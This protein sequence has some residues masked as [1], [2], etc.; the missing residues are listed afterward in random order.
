MVKFNP[1]IPE[2]ESRLLS[3]P[4]RQNFN[5]LN[6]RTDQLS[7]SNT[8]PESTSITIGRGDKVY[9]QNNSYTPFTGVVLDLGN[10]STGVAA[11]SVANLYKKVIVYYKDTGEVDFV[12][13]P[14]EVTRDLSTTSVATLMSETSV[15]SALQGTIPI[16]CVLVTNNG[17]PSVR[18]AINPI[19]E[20]DLL[21]IRPFLQRTLDTELIDDHI[22]ATSL[23]EAHPNAKVGNSQI[24][25]TNSA[26]TSVVSSTKIVLAGSIADFTPDPSKNFYPVVRFSSGGEVLPSTQLQTAR[27]LSVSGNEVTLDRPVSV[28]TSFSASKGKLT[29][30]KMN[31]DILEEF[32]GSGLLRRRSSDGYIEF[33]P[34][35]SI[36]LNS[37]SATTFTGSLTGNASTASTLQTSR[38]IA[39]SGDVAG[40]VSFNGG[41]NVTIT[42]TIQPD[43]VV[44]GTDTTGNYVAAGATSGNG[45]S[46][47]V[48]S[49][50]GTFT[51]A[52]NATDSNS[53]STIV[54]RDG[55]GNFSAGTITATLSGN[56]SNVSGV[57]AIANGGTGQT[58]ANAGLNA[59]LP[60]QTTNANRVL[61][62]DGYNAG[63][64]QITD[65]Y[66][67][68]SAAI[69]DS[70]LATISTAGKVAN[71]ATSATTSSTANTIVLR[72]SDGYVSANRYLGGIVAGSGTINII[73]G[74]GKISLPSSASQ[75]ILTVSYSSGSI[76]LQPIRISSRVG[77]DALIEGDDGYG[78][79]YIAIKV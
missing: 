67:S 50:G 1:N 79:E 61:I 7:V 75:W 78:F 70:K 43:S 23:L 30:D 38:T 34:T 15:A 18:G 20:S 25:V 42:T 29:L 77:N 41:S 74:Y 52:S 66:I 2:S 4:I 28:T 53:P 60:S 17:T 51:V 39:L 16:C 26:I 59:L 63:W 13:G 3:A 10:S 64:S 62:T 49:E 5:A 46:G 19:F 31:F 22:N 33:Q 32:Q 55:Y 76:P 73:D 37:V 65:A 36:T 9:F 14:E 54:F 12:E 45:L 71:S 27:V 11:F 47:S 6:D 56:A 8:T 44:L 24:E 35:A 40:S 57:V 68:A 21:D 72:D 69:A 48:S 58:T